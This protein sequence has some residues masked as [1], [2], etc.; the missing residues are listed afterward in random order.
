MPETKFQDKLLRSFSAIKKH[1]D[2]KHVHLSEKELSQI[3]ALLTQLSFFSRQTSESECL[4]MIGGLQGIIKSLAVEVKSE[5]KELQAETHGGQSFTED[6]LERINEYACRRELMEWLQQT[7]DNIY[8]A[9]P[10]LR[11]R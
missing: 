6:E 10:E 3:E 4:R 1:W 2:E 8:E 7:L 9:R 5:E 11:P